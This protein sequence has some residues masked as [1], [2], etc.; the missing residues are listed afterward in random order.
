M[1]VSISDLGMYGCSR[2]SRA[3]RDGEKLQ[4]QS[5]TSPCL[6]DRVGSQDE[7]RCTNP[8]KNIVQQN[9]CRQHFSKMLALEED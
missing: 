9:D 7:S 2:P 4:R 3:A 1:V 8:H 5:K 6:N